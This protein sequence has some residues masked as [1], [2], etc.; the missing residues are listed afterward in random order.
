MIRFFAHGINAYGIC[1]EGHD[2][3]VIQKLYLRY[4]TFLHAISAHHTVCVAVLSHI[5]EVVGCEIVFL[6]A[7][8]QIT[9]KKLLSVIRD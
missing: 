1:S 8:V 3:I 6:G 2:R 7:H 5:S 9:G 4:K